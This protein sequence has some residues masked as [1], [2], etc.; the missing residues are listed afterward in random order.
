MY[1]QGQRGRGSNQ[2]YI[3]PRGFPPGVMYS[4]SNGIGDLVQHAVHVG[5]FARRPST[6]E[7]PCRNLSAV[8]SHLSSSLALISL[9]TPVSS[10]SAAQRLAT[11]GLA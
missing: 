4:W 8:H 2:E 5:A 7:F 10:E 1:P 11:S 9:T 3:T 6:P